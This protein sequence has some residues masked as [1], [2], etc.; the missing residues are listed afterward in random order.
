M[1]LRRKRIAQ[2]IAVVFVFNLIVMGGGAW[3]A[4]QE[5]PPIPDRAVGPDG[6]TVM[7]GEDIRDGK[8]QFQKDGLMNHGSILGNGAYY[9]V[10]YTSDAL[11][12]KTE[13]MREY[14]AQREYNASFAQ[15]DSEQQAAISERVKNDLDRSYDGGPIEYTAAEVY[16]H[17]QVR[18]EYVNRYHEGDHQ[19]G[20]PE[21]MID[22]EA[23]ARRFA[24]FA[25]WTAWFSHTDRPDGESSYTNEWPYNPAAG[26]DATG[27]VMI[28]SVIAMVL[29]VAA[30][31]GGIWLY[32]S[33]EL[34]EPSSEGISVPDPGDVEI[35]PSQRAALRFVPV[36]AGLFLA[37]VFLGGL[38][39]HFY[40]ERAGFFGIEELFG[41]HILQ[42]LP[43]AMAKTWHIDL[44]ILWI[45][46]TWLGAGLFLPPL[47][48][49]H[50]PKRQS[51]YVNVLLGA[52]VVVAVGGLGGIWLG[53]NG[54]FESELWWILGNE[55]LE[56]LEV[57]KLWQFGLL[58]GFGLW[59]WLAVRGLKPLL[60]REPIF[61]LAHMI[62][63][64]G[65]SIALLFTAGFL[66]TPET[67]IAVTEFW[68]WWVV[69][70]WVEGAFE[71]FI[72]AIVG[73]TLVSMNLLRRQSAEKA[74][75][76]Q[77]L[78]VMGTGVIGVSHHYWWVGMPDVWIPIGSV[79]STLELLPLVFILYEALGQYTAMTEEG[80]FP[81]KIPFMFIVASGVWNF[82]G[83]GVLG[84]FINLPIINYYEHGTYLTV[85]HAHAAMFGAFGFLALGMV[86]YM[87]QLAIEPEQWDGSWLRA[88]F[89]CWNV[90]LALMVF[91][92]V[93]PVGFL[94]LEAA[95]TE[96]YAA[97]RSLAFYEQGIVQTLFWARLPG[98]TLIILG[99]VIY[100]ADIVRKRSVLRSTEPDPTTE[101]MAVA[102]G[103]LDDD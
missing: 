28:W 20:V 81:Y 63:Y 80:G 83:A 101:D 16:A 96:G 69:H 92:S 27:P 90:G 2:V 30:A 31:G 36:A 100:A 18:Q 6:E 12:L 75:M 88:A 5:S 29:L 93:L 66:F 46:A 45:A 34:P 11:S 73:V 57:G 41:T 25:M 95:F 43:F 64:A 98:D 32:R 35:V 19:R 44:G 59:A 99:T 3:F 68:R 14:Y 58:V 52:L 33:V 76:L 13:Y 71:F 94:Q 89:W 65:G 24:D 103:V 47:L 82:V 4:Y 7:T 72:V 9:G 10:D 74:V 51:T 61:G 53:S 54:F 97:A 40:I 38:L 15:L 77:A 8:E 102:E 70:M 48:T 60:D 67:N 85:G 1:K 23:D 37:Q 78:L 39:A 55:G 62:L 86:A 50:E 84:F 87:L 26:N 56:Y 17:E 21:G 91:V 42:L 79:F 49:G 22:S